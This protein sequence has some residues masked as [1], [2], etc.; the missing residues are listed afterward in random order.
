MNLVSYEF[1]ACQT[2]SHG[3][4]ILS[5]LHLRYSFEQG[6]LATQFS[7]TGLIQ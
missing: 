1:V 6:S 5:A 2:E 3:V 4:L 7:I